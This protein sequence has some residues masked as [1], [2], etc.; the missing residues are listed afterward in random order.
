MDLDAESLA[1]TSP[2]KQSQSAA[3]LNN[4][5]LIDLKNN[6]VVLITVTAKR[7][8]PGRKMQSFRGVVH[9]NTN[10]IRLSE[11]VDQ[12]L[13]E[14]RKKSARKD[15]PTSR[16]GKERTESAPVVSGGE[17]TGN[18][19]GSVSEESDDPDSGM[20][21][22]A[23]NKSEADIATREGIDAS[24]TPTSSQSS[25]SHADD[26]QKSTVI[27]GSGEDE[28]VSA[29]ALSRPSQRDP[30]G[31]KVGSTITSKKLPSLES[32]LT[33]RIRKLK[34]VIESNGY[35]FAESQL[36]DQ[37]EIARVTHGIDLIAFQRLMIFCRPKTPE[38]LM[39]GVE[40]GMILSDEEFL[41]SPLTPY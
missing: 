23:K 25:G 24:T 29:A 34:I 16:R 26:R 31:R 2:T 22:A 18:E 1:A 27:M 13:E 32:R 9:V 21:K 40:K 15:A 36:L 30:R 11:D 17:N 38:D 14:A 8:V 19:S 10:D 33:E 4:M 7:P 12:L 35:D 39:Y 6:S 3:I 5:P 20:R 41:S 28:P 37:T